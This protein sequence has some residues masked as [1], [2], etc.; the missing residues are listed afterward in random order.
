MMSM[1]V[2]AMID[3]SLINDTIKYSG[4]K[5]ITEAVKVALR[6]YIASKKLKELTA[7]IKNNP[8][9]FKH[10]AEEIRSLNRD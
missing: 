10:S 9:Q 4:A 1:K 8:L 6:E 7:Q 2:T 3:D 5:S